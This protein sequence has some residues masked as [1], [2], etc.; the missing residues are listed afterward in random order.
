MEYFGDLSSD[1]EGH[2][3][4][5]GGRSVFSV[6]FKTPVGSSMMRWANEAEVSKLLQAAAVALNRAIWVGVTASASSP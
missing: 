2:A 3:F 6:D 4:V 5:S 1:A